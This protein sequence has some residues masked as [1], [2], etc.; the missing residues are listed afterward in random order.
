MAGNHT[1][2]KRVIVFFVLFF[3]VAPSVSRAQWMDQEIL[4]RPGWNAVYLQVQPEPRE[5]EV[6]FADVPVESVWA[7]NRRFSSVQFIQDTSTLVPEQ[8]EWLTYAPP[9][10]AEDFP[11]NLFTLQGGRA[12]LIKL[13]G[14]ESISWTI[15]GKPVVRPIDWMSDSFNLVGFHVDS[16]SGPT[17]ET[18]FAP[19]AAHAGKEVYRLN[20]LGRWER[21]ENLA[22]EAIQQGVA[23]WVYCDGPSDYSGP[24][25]VTFEQGDGIDFGRILTEQTLRIRNETS[26]TAK[27]ITIRMQPSE[28]PP[29]PG[30]PL[31][32]GEVL[33]S[34]WDT[35]PDADDPNLLIS[36]WS[37]LA[38][39]LSLEV[40]AYSDVSIRLAVRRNDM[41]PAPSADSLYQNLLEVSDGDGSRM[42]LPVT[43]RGLADERAG[44]WVG[45][46]KIDKVSQ[47]ANP[48]DPNTPTP[49]ASE[50][51]MR[52]IIHVDGDGQARL[53]QQVTLM[54][55]EGTWKADPLDPSKRIVDE[56]GRYALLTRDDLMPQFSGAA[57]RDGE[58]VGRRISS[59]AFAFSEPQLM[60]G[61]FGSSL[62]CSGITVGYDDPLNPFKHKYHPDHDNLGYDFQTRLGNKKESYTIERDIELAFTSD[63]PEQLRL[64]GWGDNQVGGTYRERIRGVHKRQLH[65]EGTFRLR[66]I[67]RVA[68]LNDGL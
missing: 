29:D 37:D 25:K 45:M 23:Y 61:I 65:V 41:P 36:G 7:W 42:Q 22:A 40:P 60:V 66:H 28:S 39:T 59:A 49:T 33:L 32:A 55:K 8:P 47:P 43:A 12:Y 64:S 1:I 6:V 35:G 15:R 26:D 54:W 14:D 51:Q 62:A 46:A 16:D 19:S 13:S 63:D 3:A 18:F 56:P 58:T 57:M 24:L 30:L 27:Q 17:F 48:S 2:S 44:L 10:L 68:V 31:L 67:S 21:I 34:Y 9:D 53:L 4:L 11:I 50:F 20:T 38:T 52:L 5:C